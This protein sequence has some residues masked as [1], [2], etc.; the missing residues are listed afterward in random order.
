MG[1]RRMLVRLCSKSPEPHAELAVKT[2][3]MNR[4]LKQPIAII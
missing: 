1:R 3:R 4:Y 2:Q